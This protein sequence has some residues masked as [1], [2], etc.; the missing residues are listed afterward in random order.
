MWTEHDQLQ[1]SFYSS[2][3]YLRAFGL[4]DGL[5]IVRVVTTSEARSVPVR[6]EAESATV[7]GALC[8]SARVFA[9]VAR[10]IFE[11]N[12]RIRFVKSDLLERDVN[13]EREN[14]IHIVGRGDDLNRELPGSLSDFDRT[15]TKDH[16][17]RLKYY[18][19][20]FSRDFPHSRVV[21]LEREKITAELFDKIIEFN[22]ARMIEKGKQPG[23]NEK[24]ENRMLSVVRESGRV[25]LLLNG[26]DVCAGSVLLDAGTDVYLWAVSHDAEYDKFSPGLVCLYGGIRHLIEQ[27]FR[28]YHFLWG[29]S[30]YKRQFGA[31]PTELV[32]YA[33]VRPG[34]SAWVLAPYFSALY[35]REVRLLL[36]RNIKNANKTFDRILS[37]VSPL[38]VTG[39]HG[40]N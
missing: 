38:S 15:L 5:L 27:G 10:K 25:V 39:R 19:R 26:D 20:R 4:L 33:F 14:P 7:L 8:V 24:Y 34:K 2:S 13:L 18:E 21:V 17:K 11:S 37:A 12:D 28:R 16:L 30:E 36:A 22:R 3:P 23:I 40:R 9:L 6:L 32:S 35:K 31:T 29:D 1:T